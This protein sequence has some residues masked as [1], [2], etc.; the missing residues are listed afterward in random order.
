MHMMQE[1][2]EKKNYAGSRTLPASTK[3][4]ET[5]RPEVPLVSPTKC[6]NGKKHTLNLMRDVGKTVLAYEHYL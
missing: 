3:E 1:R 6:I 2:K 4:K 5:H